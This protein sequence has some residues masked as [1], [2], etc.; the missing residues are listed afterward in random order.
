MCDDD[1]D[2]DIDIA[3]KSKGNDNVNN[4]SQASINSCKFKVNCKFKFKFRFRIRI[5]FRKRKRNFTIERFKTRHSR[6]A[7][8]LK[9]KKPVVLDKNVRYC[10]QLIQNGSQS[11]YVES[12]TCKVSY[13]NLTIRF[14]Q[15]ERDE[16]GTSNDEG[17]IRYIYIVV[18]SNN[19]TIIFLFLIL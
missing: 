4:N 11:V 7:L 5:I 18:L 3:V 10:I 17:Q 19:E 8:K 12:V 13:K 9:L 6:Q 16:N 2:V 14:Y 15:R 1:D